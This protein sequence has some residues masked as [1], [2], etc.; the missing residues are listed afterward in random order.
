MTD[1][2]CIFGKIITGEPPAQKVDEGEP[3][4]AFMDINPA[5]RGHGLVVPRRYTRDLVGISTEDLEATVLA[6]QLR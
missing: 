3:T 5:T 2:N 1:P 4:V 6:E